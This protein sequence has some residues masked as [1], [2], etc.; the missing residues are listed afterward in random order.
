MKEEYERLTQAAYENAQELAD[1]SEFLMKA[2]K[3]PRACSLA[4]LAAEEFAKAFLCKCYSVGMITDRNFHRDLANHD[5]KLVH[6][7]KIV[8]ANGLLSRHKREID[9]A[10]RLRRLLKYH[11][12]VKITLDRIAEKEKQ[13]IKNAVDVFAQGDLIKQAGFYTDLDGK[14]IIKPSEMIT[15]Q[16]AQVVLSYMPAIRGFNLV[17]GMNDQEFRN[18]VEVLD[19]E[20]TFGSIRPFVRPV[21]QKEKF[22]A[23]LLGRK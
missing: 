10:F 22:N 15:K 14:R 8:V 20:V 18:A 4:V 6:F 16:R 17:L 7:V 11:D 2:G 3:Y 13:Q 9:E 5:V 23:A 1:E 12:I 19:Y 21:K